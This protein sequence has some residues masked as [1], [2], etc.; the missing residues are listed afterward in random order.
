MRYGAVIVAAGMSSRM[1]K[2]KPLMEIG[3]VTMAQRVIANFQRNGIKDIVLITGNNAAVLEN[4]VKKLG[5]ACIRNDRYELTQMFDS[6]K[7]GL[8]YLKNKCDRIFFCPVDIPLF[9]EETVKKLV[10]EKN[11][12]IIIPTCNGKKG[13]PI[14]INN[15]SLPSLLAYNGEGG[16]QGAIDSIGTDVEEVSLDDYG[17]LMDADTQEDFDI[18]LKLHDEQLMHPQVRVRFVKQTPFFGPGTARLLRQILYTG[19]IREAC[20]KLNIS[21]SKG[22]EMIQL[23]ETEVGKKVVIR[24]QGGINGGMAELTDYGKKVLYGYEQ[25]EDEVEKIAISCYKNIF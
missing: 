8:E 2:F 1:K 13:H 11:G 3:G 23:L 22:R 9:T 16:L 10:N 17:I 21:Y 14:L 19:S 5:V 7:L 4:E 18:L 25:Y 12:E 15:S 24:Q 6:A 20:E